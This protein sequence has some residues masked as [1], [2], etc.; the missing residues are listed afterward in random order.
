MAKRKNSG[1]KINW[2]IVWGLVAVTLACLLITF[3]DKIGLEG[4][5]TWQEIT[6]AFDPQQAD[7]DGSMPVK[8]HFFDV[9]Q[10]D[11][12]L[13][14]ANGKN[15]LI[16][17]G[18]NDQAERV[19]N[20]LKDQSID[21]IDILIGTHPHSDHIGGMD[22]VVNQFSVGEIILPKL[23]DA[24]T[25]TT[26]TYLDLLTAVA[27]KGV[28]VRRATPGDT[29]DIGGGKL[30]ILGPLSEYTDLNN[31]SVVSRF[32]YQNA[33]FWIAGDC[34]KEAEADLLAQGKVT[35]TNVYKVSH[36]GSST[37]SS[38]KFLDQLQPD[39]C[40]ISLDADNSYGHPHKEVMNRLNKMNTTV[41]RTDLNGTVTAQTDGSTI[42][43]TT[44]K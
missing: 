29:I 1:N 2:I 43:F 25:P 30:E 15:I 6:A 12:T 44:E 33:S 31:M 27:D 39:Y 10:G 28:K 32:V 11:C 26:K 8:V 41:Y 38:Q 9:G 16:D 3:G 7:D 5:P 13:I 17:A 36:H 35:Q 42:Q 4:I 19:V 22:A 21:K 18:E 34:S 24:Q 37:A 20:Y 23:S 40:V 14:S